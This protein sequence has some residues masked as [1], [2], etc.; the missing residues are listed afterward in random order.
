MGS[1]PKIE[2]FFLK[3]VLRTFLAGVILVTVSDL[4]FK[5]ANGLNTIM[6][7]VDIVIFLCV[8]AAII[9]KRL[10]KHQASVITATIFP[11]AVLFYAEMYIPN[12]NSSMIA[13]LAIGFSI[14]ILLDCLAK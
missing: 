1:N 10:K 11:L 3:I 12:S 8:V 2:E 14:S 13:I 6:L 9:L 4:I 5:S 7:I